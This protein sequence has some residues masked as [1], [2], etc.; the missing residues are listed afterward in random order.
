MTNL[1]LYRWRKIEFEDPK[2]SELRAFVDAV[3]ISE[4]HICEF[5][6][7]VLYQTP[8]YKLDIV[9]Y[10]IDRN[11]NCRALQKCVRTSIKK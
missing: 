9:D 10:D 8:F 6:P 1:G 7:K 2:K 3:C 4:L 5:I 11:R